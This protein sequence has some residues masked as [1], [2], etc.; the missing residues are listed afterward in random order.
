MSGHRTRRAA[1]AGACATLALL[2][3]GAPA[4]GA[5]IPDPQPS[6]PTVNM[7]RVLVAAQLD[8]YRPG[9]NKTAGAV[10][11]V[12][13]VQRALRKKGY[14]RVVVDGNFGST[15][16][17]AYSRWQKRAVNASGIGANGLPG[18]TSLKKLGEGRFR[19]V[20]VV[21]PGGLTSYGGSPVNLRTKR[22]LKAAA[23]RV[24]GKGCNLDLT[25]GSYQPPDGSSAATH[26]GGGAVDINSNVR[27]GK[28]IKRVRIA[29]RA[30]GFAAWYRGPN[31]GFTPHF[32]AIAISDP[33]M[34]TPISHGGQ[35][36]GM[37]QVV[38]FARKQD[39]LSSPAFNQPMTRPL[40][41]WEAYRRS[42]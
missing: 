19:V 13:R 29:L 38:G 35:F 36:T 23:R 25:K 17:R 20:R 16:M 34:S 22:M 9:N 6:L 41:T 7:G 1:G 14:R 8:D 37:H 42:Q 26:A 11:S 15:T 24:G 3:V 33:D 21:R 28:T 27:C 2:A 10:K 31:S 5:P 4:Q 30:V 40:R 12:K 39:G 18:A 32:H